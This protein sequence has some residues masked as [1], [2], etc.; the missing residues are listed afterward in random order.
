MFFLCICV[1]F[2]LS[3]EENLEAMVAAGVV[4]TLVTLLASPSV[5]VQIPAA[6]AL[7][8]L[9]KNGEFPGFNEFKF[10]ITDFSVPQKRVKS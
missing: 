1:A 5:E 3:A 10:D 9:A 7:H 2:Y 6:W 8:T 4:P